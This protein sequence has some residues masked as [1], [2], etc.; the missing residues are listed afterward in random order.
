MYTMAIRGEI[1]ARLRETKVHPRES[2]NEAIIRLLDGQ[3]KK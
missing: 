3:K 2:D 1:L